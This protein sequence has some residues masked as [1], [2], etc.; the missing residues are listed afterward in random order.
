MQV[1]LDSHIEANPILMWIGQLAL[2]VASSD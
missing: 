1:L 2:N